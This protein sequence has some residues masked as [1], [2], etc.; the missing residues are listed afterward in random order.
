MNKINTKQENLESHFFYR[1]IKVIYWA[2]LTGWLLLSAFT[3]SSTISGS[4][5]TENFA[6]CSDVLEEVKKVPTKQISNRSTGE[7]VIIYLTENNA[8]YLKNDSDLVSLGLQQKK[9]GKSQTLTDLLNSGCSGNTQIALDWGNS[10]FN[11][12][13][14]PTLV[15][16][17]RNYNFDIGTIGFATL[18][19]IGT[20]FIIIAL[21]NS[22]LYITFGIKIIKLK[23]WVMPRFYD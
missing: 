20:Y 15:H 13:I 16:T 17:E 12:K 6:Y 1:L 5:E 22:V 3:V 21:K 4:I 2:V 14:P 8:S 23:Y 18:F 9:S 11:V 19:I 10:Y 7:Q